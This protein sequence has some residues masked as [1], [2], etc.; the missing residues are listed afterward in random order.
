MPDDHT[1][2]PQDALTGAGILLVNVGTQEEPSPGAVR[3]YLAE[4]L[5]DRRVIE[6]P[7]VLWKPILHGII[8]RTRPRRTARLYS[9]IWTDAGSPFLLASQRQT[10]AIRNRL[11]ESTAGPLHV[12]L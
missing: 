12:E 8:L 9:A 3:R 4:F 6:L 5:S 2:H 1:P 11:A 10:E 7:A